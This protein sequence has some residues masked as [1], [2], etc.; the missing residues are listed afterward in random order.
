VV[1]PVIMS[2]A[3]CGISETALRC[4][5]IPVDHTATEVFLRKCWQTGGMERLGG[6]ERGAGFTQSSLVLEVW[7]RSCSGGWV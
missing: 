2:Q 1:P 4:V 6:A 7:Q 3:V 5:V